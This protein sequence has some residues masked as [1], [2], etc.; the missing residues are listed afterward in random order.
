[1]ELYFFIIFFT[2]SFLYFYILL[3]KNKEKVSDTADSTAAVRKIIL[4][5]LGEGK[6]PTVVPSIDIWTHLVSS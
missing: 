4:K 3:F 1:M 2:L 6:T 5:D